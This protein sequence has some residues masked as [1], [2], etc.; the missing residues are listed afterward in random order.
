M[1]IAQPSIDFFLVHVNGRRRE[2]R[3]CSLCDEVVYAFVC[4]RLR[5]LFVN[6]LRV[7]FCLTCG[8][9]PQRRQQRSK[10]AHRL[11]IQTFVRLSFNCFTDPNGNRQHRS[12][13]AEAKTDED[14]LRQQQWQQEQAR[15]GFFFV[16]LVVYVYA[17]RVCPGWRNNVDGSAWRC[18]SDAARCRQFFF[19]CVD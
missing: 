2:R 14:A 11:S 6:R 7:L 17:H 13:G 4:N 12:K 9:T 19:F 10:G 3:Q 18:A 1:G 5:G 8:S 16:S 15:W